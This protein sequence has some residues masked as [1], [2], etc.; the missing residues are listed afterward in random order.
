MGKARSSELR[1]ELFAKEQVKGGDANVAV[2]ERAL[3]ARQEM[4]GL[5]GYDSWASYA[6][7]VCMS[8][9][10]ERSWRSWRTCASGWR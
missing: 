10:R 2:L 9:E 5:L 3:A 4:A 8:K 1:R 6:H 7:E